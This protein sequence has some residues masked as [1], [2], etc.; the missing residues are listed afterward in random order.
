MTQ[1]DN[2]LHRIL[3]QIH[4]YLW[5]TQLGMQGY[6][7]PTVYAMKALLTPLKT[8]RPEDAFIIGSSSGFHLGRFARFALVAYL[9]TQ[10]LQ[11]AAATEPSSNAQ[12]Q[13]TIIA[14]VNVA[15]E[16]GRVRRWGFCTQMAVCHRYVCLA[17][18]GPLELKL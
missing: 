12:L 18:F 17:R 15:E 2:S 10:A 13:R 9:L 5:M 7:L 4:T 3:T 11:Q 14:L 8:S 6:A 16:E 1:D